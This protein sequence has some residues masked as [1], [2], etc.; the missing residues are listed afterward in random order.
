MPAPD[1][2]ATLSRHQGG[3]TAQP[4]FGGGLCVVLG[5]FFA[6]G[7]F[8]GLKNAPLA[9]LV[10]LGMAGAGVWM[11]RGAI[12]W[13]RVAVELHERGLVYIT[14]GESFVCPFGNVANVTVRWVR[15]AG[16]LGLGEI[17]KKATAL[18]LHT[19]DGR[20]L[21]LKPALSDFD[22]L[23]EKLRAVLLLY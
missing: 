20:N 3:L 15:D 1:L 21:E 4:I 11:I 12:A 14:G 8:I 9:V 10:G 19:R 17:R 18:I 2:G 23:A 6:A 7:P 22:T 13:T 16:L 5:L